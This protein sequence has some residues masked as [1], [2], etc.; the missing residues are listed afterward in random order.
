MYTS[1]I[2]LICKMSEKKAKAAKNN[3]GKY[4][5][6]GI[7]TGFYMVIAIILSY[8]TGAMLYPKYPEVAKVIIAATFCFAIAQVVF[9]SGELFTSNNFVMSVGLMKKKVNVPTVLK[10][11]VLTLIANAIGIIFLS[12]LFVKSGASLDIISHYIE[13][14]ANGKLELTPIQMLLRG[15]LCNFSVCLAYLGGIKMKSESGKFIMI[16][17][18][19]FAFIIAGFEHSIANI[20]IF[21]IAYFSLG[22]LPMA[23]V[24]KN[25]FFVI[26]GNII[27]GGLL[28]GGSLTYISVDGEN[29]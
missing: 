14:V 1:D 20:G 9:F 12:F 4:I 23:L 3:L 6:R 15:I 10:I 24:L 22:G 19:V 5:G 27:G 16:F 28:L 26:I 17:F 21:S 25:L 11:W 29:K 8:T 2:E 13:K 7:V 18:A